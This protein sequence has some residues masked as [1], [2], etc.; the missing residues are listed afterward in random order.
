MKLFLVIASMMVST[1]AFA[2]QNCTPYTTGNGEQAGEW[3]YPCGPNYTVTHRACNEGEV[4]YFPVEY[5]SEGVREE[6]R[7]CHNGTFFP[8]QAP[9][10]HRGCQEGQYAYTSVYN[11]GEGMTEVTI[12]CRNGRF[13]PAN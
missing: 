5:T 6:A 12:V 3:V 4:A 7:V 11:G 10:R 2:G 13:V 9:V 1:A 8:R